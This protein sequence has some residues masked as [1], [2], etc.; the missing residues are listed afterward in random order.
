MEKGY[1]RG[2]DRDYLKGS[3]YHSNNVE[4]SII[5]SIGGELT[6]RLSRPPL[7]PAAQGALPDLAARFTAPKPQ[8]EKPKWL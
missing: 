4:R 3:P 2:I 8:D 6:A 7:G 5:G 1:G